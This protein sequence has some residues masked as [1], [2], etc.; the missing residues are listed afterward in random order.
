MSPNSDTVLA[1]ARVS[2]F[3][4]QQAEGY[5]GHGDYYSAII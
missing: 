5:V 1:P 2:A 4:K 3:S